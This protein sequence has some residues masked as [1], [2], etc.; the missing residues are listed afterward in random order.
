MHWL[1][2]NSI[3]YLLGIRNQVSSIFSSWNNW[4]TLT[5]PQSFFIG[6]FAY[7]F[8]LENQSMV[9]AVLVLVVFDFIT[10]IISK[11]RIG[12]VIESRKA[13]KSATKTV[14]YG[15]FLSSAH[16]TGTVLPAGELLDG[17]AASF[18]AITE[19]ISIIENIGKMG[20]VMPK[21]LLNRLYELRDEK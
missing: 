19:F 14:I 4:V 12:E 6:A 13:L 9:S 5:I 16:L 7:L 3:E 8:G 17:I 10:A 15:I 11:Y 2:P 18:L 20:Y 1:T 21:K